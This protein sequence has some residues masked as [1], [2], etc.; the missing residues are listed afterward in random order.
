MMK[1]KAMILKEF[2]QP[3]Q[4]SEID[5]P[6]LKKGEILIKMKAAGVCGSDVHMWRGHDPRTPKPLILGHEGVGE[7]IEMKGKRRAVTGQELK[8]GDLVLWNR[9][10]SC[11]E[12]YHCQ[13][14]KEP[15]FC[16]R[17]KVYGINKSCREAPYLNGCYSEYIILVPSTDLFVIEDEIRPEILVS[18]SCSGATMAHA[19]DMAQLQVGDIVLIQGPGPLGIYAVA[20]AKAQGASS[21]IVIGGSQSRLN[22]CK[23]FGA[24]LI[25]NRRETSIHERRE[26]IYK[27]TKGLGVDIGIEAA[28]AK[29]VVEEGIKLVRVGGTYLTTGYSQPAGY[30]QIDFFREIVRKNLKIQG[31]WV[32]DT[33][34]T[35][36][37]MK[38]V[39]GNKEL[40]S[41]MITHTY[42]LDQANEALKVM[43]NREALKAVLLP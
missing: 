10:I 23:R 12:C 26:I 18:A 8:V 24:D 27:H 22:Q 43:E 37:A 20:F 28:G 33:S 4:L 17:R 6:E 2:N 13:V 3:L 41:Q 31:V 40:F 14:L 9:G 39:L 36:K 16:E 35:L 32:S 34:H 7:I 11:G 21:I 30:E 1:S 42:S 5:I 19:F 38:L 29:G 25:L 15:S